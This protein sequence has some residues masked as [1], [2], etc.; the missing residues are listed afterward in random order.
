MSDK[1]L[2]A[3]YAAADRLPASLVL[4]LAGASAFSVANVY[5]AQPLLDAIA[6]DF[7]I[8]LAAVGM[9]ITVTQL[10]CALALLLVVPLGDR[11]N[12]RRLLAAQ[13]LLL[14]AALLAVGWSNSSLLLLAGMLL[15][16]LL[17]TAMTQGLI[18]FA[19]TLAAPHE[20]GRVVGAAQGGVVLGLLLARTLSGALA[21]IGGWRTVYFFSAGV[22]LVLLPI[23]AR[24][25][26]ALQTP[27]QT[28]S[29]PAL[30]RS[31]LTLLRRDRT[32]QI[33]GM[34][35]LLM[36]AAFSI[37]WSALVLPLS[38]PPFNFSHSVVGAFGLVGAVGALAAM[39]AGHLADRGLGQLASGVCLLLL[40][41]AWLPLGML[42]YGL[43][44]LV[45]GIVL[46]DLAGQAIHVL[47]QSMIF[48]AHPQ[49]HSRLVG[50]YM[51]FYAAG[52][53]LGA[54]ASTHVYAW[55][56]WSGVCWL[57]ASVSLGALL[58]WRLTLRAMPERP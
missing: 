7:G 52:S 32:L 53:G 45:A 10:G 54:F 48:N 23:L 56:G 36:F 25:L 17:G 31:M 5:Y 47:N 9:V 16:G 51:L 43:I 14:I 2:D 15:V 58:F 44:W 4:L 37:F 42:G 30:L 49:S 26:P 38:R 27:P 41:L 21:D 19:A 40:T 55:A 33:R 13:Q 3:P 18:A 22:T 8:S 1:L 46:L 20:R 24:L 28:L 11:V 34:L 29:Y 57:G 35:A 50:C 6:A 39:R 12:R